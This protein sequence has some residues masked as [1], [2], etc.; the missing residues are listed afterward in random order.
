[1]V[2]LCLSDIHGEKAGLEEVLDSAPEA[3]AIVIA[4]DVTQRGRYE[5]AR[6]TL[7]P[8]VSRKLPIF[9]VAGNMDAEDA[10]RH[11]GELGIDIHGRGVTFKGIGIQGLGGSNPTPMGT[12]FELHDEEAGILLYAGHAEIQSLP[13]RILVSHAPPKGTK[14]DVRSLGRH[15]GSEAVRSFIVDKQPD[16]CIS[17]HIHESFGQD[18]LGR[19]LCI[20]VASYKSGRYAIVRIDGQKAAVSW[21]KR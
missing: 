7:E 3:E 5:E 4:G 15:V 2:L 12:P 6:S 17:G 1:M 9:A 16:L 18:M 8:L 13:F 19:T 21:R 11:L 20:N 14:T 10:R